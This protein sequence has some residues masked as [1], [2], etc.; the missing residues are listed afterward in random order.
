MESLRHNKS[1]ELLKLSDIRL[2][3]GQFREKKNVRIQ[4]ENWFNKRDQLGWEKK[5]LTIHIIWTWDTSKLI[6]STYP[7]KCYHRFPNL[8][9]H[10]AFEIK[11][12]RIEWKTRG[13]W[14]RPD[15]IIVHVFFHYFKFVFYQDQWSQKHDL[16]SS[17]FKN[18][19]L[20]PGKYVENTSKVM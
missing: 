3:Y 15:R 7:T 20:S 8:F 18:L 9:H 10:R 14:G 2:D 16:F 1:A 5:K 19:P 17:W 11:R 12:T 4:R 6:I 13:K